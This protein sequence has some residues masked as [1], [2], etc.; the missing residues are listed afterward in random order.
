MRRL[1]AEM[2]MRGFAYRFG[3]DEYVTLFPNASRTEATTVHNT[4]R[5]GVARL[6]YPGIAKATTV[7][8]GFCEVEPDSVWTGQEILARANAAKAFANSSGKD[9]VA[10]YREGSDA[11]Y[12]VAGAGASLEEN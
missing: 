9:R 11:L 5:T 8:V 1:E 2:F 4:I 3:G 12:I 6:Q 10:T 7:A